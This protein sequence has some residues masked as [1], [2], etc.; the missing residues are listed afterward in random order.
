MILGT[1]SA[2]L[3]GACAARWFHPPAVAGVVACSV[4]AASAAGLV[5]G[6][7]IPRLIRHWHLERW[8]AMVPT[9]MA[10]TDIAALC[11]YLVLAGAIVR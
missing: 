4:L 6:Y 9:V 1:T 11:C 2:I 10:V 8:V 7:A 5:T 3:T